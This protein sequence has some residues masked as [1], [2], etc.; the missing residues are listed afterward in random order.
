MEKEWLKPKLV[1]LMRGKPEERVLDGCK[2]S[3]G[4]ETTGA[5]GQ[6]LCQQVEDPLEPGWCDVCNE[7]S[8]T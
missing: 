6:T 4:E 2:N 8:A 5:S 1:V 7:H 3:V